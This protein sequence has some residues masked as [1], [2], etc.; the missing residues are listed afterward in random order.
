MRA[1]T[2]NEENINFERGEDPRKTLGLGGKSPDFY[3]DF[4]TAIEEAFH[5]HS[6][7]NM[8]VMAE[9]SDD[10]DEVN[11]VIWHNVNWTDQEGRH[12]WLEI[13]LRIN[14][15]T[16]IFSGYGTIE[17]KDGRINVK[18]HIW[19]FEFHLIG[20]DYEDLIEEG[21]QAVEE[22]YYDMDNAV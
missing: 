8:K 16:N 22:L 9:Q 14:F 4:N 15:E 3:S 18:K 7:Q 1:K 19:P 17:S 6:N 13:Y 21:K 11:V 10:S 2:I 5:I 12:P 20:E